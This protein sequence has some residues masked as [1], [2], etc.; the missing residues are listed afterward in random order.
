VDLGISRLHA[1]IPNCKDEVKQPVLIIC[2]E[3]KYGSKTTKVY[4]PNPEAWPLQRVLV[5]HVQQGVQGQGL[6]H[7]QE[8]LRFP[9]KVEK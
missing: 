6:V 3:K 5:E 1:V 4:V 9:A 8:L 2:T 7:S